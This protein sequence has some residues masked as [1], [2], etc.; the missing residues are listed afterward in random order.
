M[1]L[2]KIDVFKDLRQEAINDISEIAREEYYDKGTVLFS[3][4]EPADHFY[5]LVTGNVGL[6]VG[7]AATSHY[8]VTRI[9]ESFGWSSV[10]GR[11]TYSARAE[12]V[13]PSRVLKISRTDLERVFDAHARSGRVFYRRLAEAM[14]QRWID[15]HR[16]FMSQFTLTQA[17]TYGTG[18]TTGASE[19]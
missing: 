7:D 19:M 3:A 15:L 11:D 9:G 1:F 4:G 12:C 17:A 10:V 16:T 6:A 14:G 18:Q 2:P 8:S 13:A 5:I